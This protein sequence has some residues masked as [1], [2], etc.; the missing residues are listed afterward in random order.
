M[1]D[2]TAMRF[3][4]VPED[5]DPSDRQ[6]VARFVED[7]R[8]RGEVVTGLLYANED[9]EDLHDL[10]RTPAAALASITYDRLCPGAGELEK[11]QQRFR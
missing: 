3:R 11:L 8:A 2:G 10:N 6:A 7:H 1:H 5:Y 9:V 4:A